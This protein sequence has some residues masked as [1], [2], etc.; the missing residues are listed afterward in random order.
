MDGC[1]LR[2]GGVI[3]TF[4][5]YLKMEPS[6]LTKKKYKRASECDYFSIH[7]SF[8][9]RTHEKALFTSNLTLFRSLGK[10]YNKLVLIFIHSR[11]FFLLPCRRRRRHYSFKHFSDTHTHK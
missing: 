6:H 2:C 1:V 7:S 8:D 4:Y 10:K 9:T 5:F 11:L 3:D